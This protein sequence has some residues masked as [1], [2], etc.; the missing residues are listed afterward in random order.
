MNDHPELPRCVTIEPERPA[1]AAVI[2]LHG[3]GADG[4]DFEPI[5]PLL[6]LPDALAVR[7]RFPHAPRRPVAI[8]NGM[9]MRAWYDIA[10]PGPG[11]S[12]DESG[13]RASEAL[14]HR[15]IEREISAGIP[16]ERIALAGFSQ[17][18][19]IALQ[20]GLRHPRALA[21]IAALS[22]YLPLAASLAGEAADANRRVPILM[23]HGRGDAIIPI[24]NAQ[25]SRDRLL[26]AG[27]PVEWHEYDLGHS[28]NHLVIKDISNWLGRALTAPATS[29]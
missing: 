16:P 21:G 14:L 15:L 13:I 18:G 26:A 29:S 23:T 19:A 10:A 4:H 22:T 17:G 11:W 2:W 7:Y 20:A 28:V 25:R 8:N 3:L 6:E 12:E 9:V 1:N 27:H 24:A 5:V